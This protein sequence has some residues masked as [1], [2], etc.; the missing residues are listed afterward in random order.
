MD[1]LMFGCLLAFCA[2]SLRKKQLKM[3]C[4]KCL[5]LLGSSLTI[6]TC[7]FTHTKLNQSDIYFVANPGRARLF[8]DQSL[9]GDDTYEPFLT[10]LW[11]GNWFIQEK[12]CKILASIVSSRPK[13]QDRIV[14]NGGAS[15]SKKIFTTIDDVLKDLVQWLCAQVCF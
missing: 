14:A 11:N 3:Y 5:L 2:I 10:L 13:P 12:S 15:N 7:C 6:Y 8:H 4:T 1:Q 9:S